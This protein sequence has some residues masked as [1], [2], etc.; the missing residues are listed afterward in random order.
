[1]LL[2][3]LIRCGR[4]PSTEMGTL[5]EE[6]AM[7]YRLVI[8]YRDATLTAAVMR[9]FVKSLWIMFIEVLTLVV[10]YMSADRRRDD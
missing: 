7:L 10:L 1:M 4:D 8:K 5:Q 6:A 3:T 2:R 9:P